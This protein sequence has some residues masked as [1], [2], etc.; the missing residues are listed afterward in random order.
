MSS[1]DA[2]VF[3]EA[4]PFREPSCAGWGGA[5]R[6]GG[7][8][9][10][11]HAPLWAGVNRPDAQELAHPCRFLGDETHKTP[12]P[13]TQAEEVSGRRGQ[14]FLSRLRGLRP[15]PSP[16]RTCRGGRPDMSPRR[17]ILPGPTSKERRGLD[18]GSGRRPGRGGAGGAGGLRRRGPAL[19]CSPITFLRF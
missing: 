16:V 15:P 13:H 9:R 14:V 4:P 11:G 12:A 19:R 1:K 7:A 5:G 10:L 2:Q 6:V 8:C 18:A 17:P 3:P